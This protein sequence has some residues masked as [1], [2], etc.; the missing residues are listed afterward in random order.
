MTLL[1]LLPGLLCDARLWAPQVEALD[2]EA[3]VFIPDLTRDETM[4]VLARRVLDEAPADTFAL[5]GL[6]MGGYVAMEMMRQAPDRVSRLAL[7]DTRARP[8]SPDET[9]RRKTLMR[10]AERAKGFAPINKRMLPL[11]VH[12]SRLADRSLFDVI[13][14][15]AEDIGIPGY[16]RQ[17]QAIMSR[18]DF[19]PML[20]QI[21]CPTLLLCGRQDAITTVAMHEEI[22]MAIPQARFVIVEECGHLSTLEKPAEVNAALQAWLAQ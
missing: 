15:M 5:A 11:L 4:E 3:D 10:I 2:G 17:Q 14:Q 20:K 13:Q 6:S 7:L 16:L 18:T 9:E 19:R 22:A 21:A 12:P 1:V 8:D